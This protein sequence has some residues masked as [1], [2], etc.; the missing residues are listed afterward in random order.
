MSNVVEVVKDEAVDS[1]NVDG[2]VDILNGIIVDCFKYGAYRQGR[3]NTIAVDFTVAA[4]MCGFDPLTELRLFWKHGLINDINDDEDSESR[5]E[6]VM[7]YDRDFCWEWM[8]DP[9]DFVEL[10]EEHTSDM[11]LK[12]VLV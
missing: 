11:P 1:E 2:Y 9:D 7:E 10:A 6:R 12:Y 5:V 3:R 4:H 8:I